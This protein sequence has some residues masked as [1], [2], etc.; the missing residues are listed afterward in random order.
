MKILKLVLALTLCCVVYGM[1]SK[2]S[3][4]NSTSSDEEGLVSRFP[5]MQSEGNQSMPQY[6]EDIDTADLWFSTSDAQSTCPKDKDESTSDVDMGPDLTADVAMQSNRMYLQLPMFYL[7]FDGLRITDR[8]TVVLNRQYFRR[9]F[10]PMTHDLMDNYVFVPRPGF[11]LTRPLATYQLAGRFWDNLEEVDGP[12]VNFIRELTGISRFHYASEIRAWFNYWTFVQIEGEWVILEPPLNVVVHLETLD[13]GTETHAYTILCT[14]DTMRIG[15]EPFR[16]ELSTTHFVTFNPSPVRLNPDFEPEPAHMLQNPPPHHL[17]C[18]FTRNAQEHEIVQE[19]WAR[20]S[21][22]AM[23]V[24]N[25]QRNTVDRFRNLMITFESS[26]LYEQFRNMA[27][28]MMAE[29]RASYYDRIMRVNDEF[30]RPDQAYYNFF[31]DIGAFDLRNSPQPFVLYEHEDAL[32][33]QSYAM[34]TTLE[35]RDRRVLDNLLQNAR[36][37]DDPDES[38]MLDFYQYGGRLSTDSVRINGNAMVRQ[39]S[40][41]NPSASYN[42]NVH[43]INEEVSNNVERRNL[44]NSSFGRSRGFFRANAMDNIESLPTTAAP[45][46]RLETPMGSIDNS[47]NA[48]RQSGQTPATAEDTANNQP[49]TPAT[50]QDQIS[51]PPPAAPS[52]GR[53]RGRGRG[54]RDNFKTCSDDQSL[55]F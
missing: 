9:A 25:E 6:T 4:K 27:G 52:A 19:Q 51:T 5:S 16:I 3:R 55:R 35:F 17:E 50:R 22:A 40:R 45:L 34:Q 7:H 54:R 12:A 47:R 29:F 21:E 38:T 15:N 44:G 26:Q 31:S 33:L 1:P 10:D 41:L 49:D 11:S 48:P 28:N 24:C 32:L 42:H 18:W 20:L 13:R 53:G 43:Q 2:R 23:V 30:R 36:E 39:I 14:L 8:Q 46:V 37:Q